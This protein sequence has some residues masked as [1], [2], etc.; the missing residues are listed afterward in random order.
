MTKLYIYKKN[1]KNNVSIRQFDEIWKENIVKM[2]KFLT[3]WEINS[4]VHCFIEKLEGESL[5]N[6]KNKHIFFRNSILKKQL[7]RAI[8]VLAANEIYEDYKALAINKKDKVLYIIA[9]ALYFKWRESPKLVM[10]I[11]DFFKK[12]AQ[13]KGYKEQIL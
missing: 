7:R 6:S 8:I 1:Q 11:I 13:K 12:K 3:F 9:D 4:L 2:I 5:I 10:D